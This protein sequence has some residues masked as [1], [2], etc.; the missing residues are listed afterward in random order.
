MED[1]K[2]DARNRT[3]DNAMFGNERRR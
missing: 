2:S 1:P 3:G